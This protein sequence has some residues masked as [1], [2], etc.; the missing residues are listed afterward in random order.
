LCPTGAALNPQA[1]PP[2]HR[3][4]RLPEEEILDARPLEINL[5]V[6]REIAG[7]QSHHYRLLL[8]KGQFA[9][10]VAEQ[11]GMD[12]V[13]TITDGDGRRIARVDRPNGS[14]GPEAASLIA[15]ESG[16]YFLSIRSLENEVASAAYK[17][18][19]AEVRPATSSDH[20]R[21]IAERSITEGEVMR[22]KMTAD[23]SREALKHFEQALIIWRALNE[24]YEEA[25]AL[26]GIGLTYRHLGENPAAFS[27]FS[28]GLQLMRTIG[29]RYGE[30]ITLTAIAW[31]YLYLG[32]TKESLGHFTDAL[33]IRRL[34]GD[35]RGEALTLHGIGS[36]HDYL[37]DYGKAL[38]YFTASL[39]IRVA[40]MDRKGQALTMI[41]MGKAYHRAGRNTEALKHLAQALELLRQIDYQPGL[42][43]A[44]TVLGWV[45]NALN[46]DRAA[47]D[48]FQRALPIGQ[49]TGNS[50]GQVI[51]LYGIAAVERRRGNLLSALERIEEALAIVEALRGKGETQQL[52][53]SS[54]AV[55]QDYY[56]FYIDLLMHL[57]S[58]DPSKGYCAKALQASESAR[59]RTMLDLLAEAQSNIGHGVEPGLV[60]REH[61]LKRQINA[62][63]E[64]KN[65]LLSGRSPLIQVEAQERVIEYLKSARNEVALQIKQ[66]S[67][68]YAALV[69]PQPLSL[70]EIQQLLDPN[71]ML[72]EFA[73]GER[74][75]F[76]WVV[77]QTRLKGI[78]LP[79]RAEI[80]EAARQFYESLIARNIFHQSESPSQRRVRIEGADAECQASSLALSRMIFSRCAQDLTKRRL[81]IVAQG[82]L[83]IIPFAAL[84]LPDAAALPGTRLQP[85]IL[86][87]EVVSLPSASTL[88]LLRQEAAGREAAPKTIAI[89]ADPV[90]S[91]DD[92]RVRA[93]AGEAPP[94]SKAEP[95]Y[96]SE[97]LPRLFGTRLESNSI[98]S[99]LAPGEYL[100]A[101][102]FEANKA[103]VTG[104]ELSRYRIIHFATHA[105]IDSSRPEL[106]A[107][108]LSRV[109]SRGVPRQ[110]L[111]RAH[112]IFHM[113]LNAELVVLSACRT[114]LGKHVRGEGL[115][116]LTRGFMYAGTPRVV[117]S[118]WSL[119]D[120]S[121]SELM[122]RFYK[123][124]FG[125]KR[126]SPA[127]AL[128]EAQLEI[129][130]SRRW[131][132][133]YFWAAFVLQ[134]EWK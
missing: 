109:D 89:F 123:A 29:D 59:A 49:K 25:I 134:G 5:P 108:A 42:A 18:C 78:E 26:Y 53:L 121:A 2:S 68:Q 32:E 46:D 51:T 133:P 69:R 67:P 16:S 22:G 82:I 106:S 117:V 52:R 128:R 116:G 92:E 8:G 100:Q 66:G 90:F 40:L 77:T 126:L 58:L 33:A 127:A 110:G 31:T 65:R 83:Q 12:I 91:A 11:R 115:L 94:A 55:V 105:L 72:L 41:S 86:K 30:A 7:A 98:T 95:D 113:K 70:F 3:D 84:S 48:Y 34:L 4:P 20:S 85:L 131:H 13:L 119:E 132:S 129:L 56:E 14:Y 43:E 99:L 39:A 35:R 104:E 21:I 74:R 111:L 64:H 28:R 114:G 37:G 6:E 63:V 81:A 17:L 71:T 15:P 60:E 61:E 45:H 10:I 38:E 80:E 57:D 112:E 124:L 125:R 62:A 102:D 36:A 54:F 50:T 44:M 79:A 24:P 130:K 1:A 97:R 118:L 88:S 120:S 73:L 47:L 101:L 75:S 122:S 96:P 23:S 19:L 107:I 87:H 93:G 27:H 103:R 76:L 9:R